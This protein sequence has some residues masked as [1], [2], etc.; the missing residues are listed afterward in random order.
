MLELVE[1]LLL[2][3]IMKQLLVHTQPNWT[4]FFLIFT[5][6]E[7]LDIMAQMWHYIKF[8]SYEPTKVTSDFILNYLKKVIGG[9]TTQ[10]NLKTNT[11][12]LISSIW[13]RPQRPQGCQEKRQDPLNMPFE[14]W[15][16][17]IAPKL[18]NIRKSL[19]KQGF[20]T[21]FFQF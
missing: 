15:C 16:A 21:F 14:V 6:F 20:L 18:K 17:K 2:K 8:F 4:L 11:K 3:N 19:R 5:Y 10:K 7:V 1:P 12:T 13:I 9:A